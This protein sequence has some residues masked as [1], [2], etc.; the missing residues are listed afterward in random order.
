LAVIFVRCV[1]AATG[2]DL[3]GTGLRTGSPRSAVDHALMLNGRSSAAAETIRIMYSGSFVDDA[4]AELAQ[5]AQQHG[6][7]VD[8]GDG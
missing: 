4:F 8:S 7:L 2:A 1:D 6:L 5:F 3:P